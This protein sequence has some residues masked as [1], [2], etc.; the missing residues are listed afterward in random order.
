MGDN[1][2]ILLLI[3]LAEW[4]YNFYLLKMLSVDPVIIEIVILLQ[5]Y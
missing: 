1:N 3:P 2:K 5:E 4:Y